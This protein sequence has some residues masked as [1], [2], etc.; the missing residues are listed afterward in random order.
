MYEK[1]IIEMIGGEGMNFKSLLLVGFMLVSGVA[2]A[3]GI[4]EFRFDAAFYEAPTKKVV[5]RESS[6]Q[7]LKTKY[8]LEIEYTDELKGRI[9]KQQDI[10]DTQDKELAASKDMDESQVCNN[11]GIFYAIV[12]FFVGLLF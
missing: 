3:D 2:C 6:Y 8:N 4:D 9:S 10:I 5:S 1:N 7:R 11:D 12:G